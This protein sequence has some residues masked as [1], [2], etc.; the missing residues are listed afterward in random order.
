MIGLRLMSPGLK[1]RQQN[2]DDP[3]PKQHRPLSPHMKHALSSSGN[4]RR[5]ECW[6]RVRECPRGSIT[7]PPQVLSA[8]I[9]CLLEQTLLP[10]TR[11]GCCIV[12][13]LRGDAFPSSPLA[14][15]HTESFLRT[16]RSCCVLLCGLL[17]QRG[18]ASQPP[19]R[20]PAASARTVPAAPTRSV[21]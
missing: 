2:G 18:G 5:A 4:F 6:C 17:I 12:P 13:N 21:N 3:L 8:F 7:E 10:H 20:L 16:R 19:L 14:N 11:C 9:S 1:T 15:D